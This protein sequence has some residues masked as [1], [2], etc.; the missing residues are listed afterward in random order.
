MKILKLSLLMILVAGSAAA[1]ATS[2]TS[3]APDVAVVEISWRRVERINPRLTDT[4]VSASPDY[5]A[6]MAVNTARINENQSVRDGG[7][8]PAPPVLLSVPSIPDSPPVMMRPWSGFV[9]EFTV[10]NTGAKTIKQMA[11]EYSFTDPSTQQKVGLRQYKSKVKIRPGTTAKIV[12]RSN[13]PPIGTIDAT[14]TGRNPHQQSPD[15]M[16]IQS[17]KYADGS[18]WKRD[19]K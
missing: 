11:F 2:A 7:G 10:K 14:Q 19:S 9:Y 15:Q 4:R 1:Q 13:R 12:V 18:V 17:I 5:A 6:R 16:V 8:N 3:G